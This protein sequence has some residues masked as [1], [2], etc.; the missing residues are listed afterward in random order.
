MAQADHSPARLFA[1]LL[2]LHPATLFA[3][4]SARRHEARARDAIQRLSP[5][6]RED[7]ALPYEAGCTSEAGLVEMAMRSAGRW[8]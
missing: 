7:L 8:P 3:G 2:D 5:H 4:W 1:G 6:L